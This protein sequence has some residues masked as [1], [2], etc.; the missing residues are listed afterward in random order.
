MDSAM[1][2]KDNTIMGNT[3]MTKQ[4]SFAD[5]SQWARTKVKKLYALRENWNQFVVIDLNGHDYLMNV[6][7]SKLIFAYFTQ[8]TVISI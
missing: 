3:K 1:K 7:L 5:E 6:F 2:G 4:N 8:N